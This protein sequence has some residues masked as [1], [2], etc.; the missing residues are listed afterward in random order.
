MK[1]YRLVKSV[2]VSKITRNASATPIAALK[3]H[4]AITRNEF[5]LFVNSI[6]SNNPPLFSLT[7]DTFYQIIARMSRKKTEKKMSILAGGAIH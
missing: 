3:E 6:I 4:N 2:F 7:I 1:P 5:I